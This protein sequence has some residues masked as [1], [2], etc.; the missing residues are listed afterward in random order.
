MK[1]CLLLVI[2]Q[3]TIRVYVIF[4]VCVA[5]VHDSDKFHSETCRHLSLVVATAWRLRECLTTTTTTATTHHVDV[6]EH[7]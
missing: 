6:I 7:T 1:F 3:L 5:M 4:Q 2:F